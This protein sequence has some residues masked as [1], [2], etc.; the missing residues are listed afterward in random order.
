MGGAAGLGGGRPLPGPEEDYHGPDGFTYT[1]GDG[2]G[3]T[4]AAA[5]TLTVTS[6]NDA[7][8]AG[9]DA[10]ST[11][12]DTPLVVPAPGLAANDSDEDGDPLTTALQTGP[13]NGAVTVGAYGSFT[14]TPDA[15]YNG[16]DSFTY[17][18]DDGHSPT[19]TA[20]ATITVAAGLRPTAWYLGTTGPNASNWGTSTSPGP[21]VIPKP[22]TTATRP[23]A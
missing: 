12:E 3:G 18:L 21:V 8:L 17:T 20:T 1:I 15:G 6:V 22:I 4:A 5:V 2:H 16:T 23:L 19:A 9:A 14:Y 13:A 7:P 11:A 10:Y